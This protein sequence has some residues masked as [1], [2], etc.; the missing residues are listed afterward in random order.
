MTVSIT[1]GWKKRLS[2]WLGAALL[3]AAAAVQ[4]GSIEPQRAELVPTEDGY[5]LS[6]EF[7]VDLGARLEEAV[8]RGLPL[9]FTVEFDLTRQRW[10]WANEHVAGRRLDYRL[11]Y[12]ALTRKYRLSLGALHQSF[13]TLSEALRAISRIAALPVAARG[14]LKPGEAYSAALRLSLDRSQLPKPLQVDALANRDWQVDAK[15]LRWQ[16]VASENK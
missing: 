8:A 5:A 6:A 9:Y 12:N 13:D 2:A 11:A 15:V 4:A 1:P 14:A 7:A 3:L 10:Y 16:F